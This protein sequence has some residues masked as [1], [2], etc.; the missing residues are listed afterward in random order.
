MAALLIILILVF[1][2][3]G[4]PIGFSLGLS[5]LGVLLAD[6][7][8]PL[9]V[10]PQ[11]MMN[12]IDSFPLLAIPFFMLAGELM[13]R[14]GL[15][16]KIIDV[17]DAYAGNIPG[18]LTIVTI[19]ASAI[20]AAI[21]GSAVATVAAIG[22]ITMAGMIKQGY[23]NHYAAAVAGAASI[24]GPIIPPSVT[25][26]VYGSALQIS[27]SDL[28]QASMVP[29]LL[30]ALG[31]SVVSYYL[32]KK[33]NYPRRE[34][35][36]R[37]EKRQT[38]KD[39]FWALLMP[40]IIL[41]GIFSGLF[42]PTEAAVVSVVY[43]L[44]IGFFVYKSLNIKDLVPVFGE[45]AVTTSTIMIILAMSKALSWVV[46]MIDLPNAVTQAMLGLTDNKYIILFLINIV[47][48][49][50]GML[51]EA[52]AALV[53]LIPVLVPLAT[54]LGVDPIHFGIIMNTNLCIGLM[55]PP[56]GAS[57]LLSNQLA[58]ASF[59]QTV[60][61]VIPYILVALIVLLLV[62]YVPAISLT[63]PEILG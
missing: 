53:I 22:G 11:K 56:V 35:A 62:T 19:V 52:N 34:K 45:A 47:L 29:G 2:F 7:N 41:G 25:L 61:S 38:L 8:F 26:I 12:G 59:E 58:D 54:S 16:R 49:I 43:A 17:A 31:F 40:I 44:F 36:S 15:N 21:S 1:A 48:L 20:F 33:R 28:F 3:I 6:G 9:V 13:N 10:I 39:G 30:M 50:V 55:T 14:G 57:V 32:S 27:V 24:V 46:T 37:E 63:L 42:T 60:K 18:S 51:M 4:V 23:P 5:S